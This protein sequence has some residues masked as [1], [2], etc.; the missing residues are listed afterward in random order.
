[1]DGIEPAKKDILNCNDGHIFEKYS[2]FRVKYSTSPDYSLK[3]HLIEVATSLFATQFVQEC[4]LIE[5]KKLRKDEYDMFMT[6]LH[7][8]NNKLMFT[9]IDKLTGEYYTQF[10]DAVLNIYKCQNE[11]LISQDINTFNK[12][13]PNNVFIWRKK[14]SSDLNIRI[15]GEKQNGKLDFAVQSGYLLDFKTKHHRDLIDPFELVSVHFSSVPDFISSFGVSRGDDI[16]LPAFVLQWMCNEHWKGE[17]KKYAIGTVCIAGIFIGAGIAG[18]GVVSKEV[19][20]YLV[21]EKGKEFA[22]A[23]MQEIIAGGIVKS[24]GQA[25]INYF[26]G[27]S[28]NVEEE[29]LKTFTSASF[30]EGAVKNA[31]SSLTSGFEY[32]KAAE[33]IEIV[34]KLFNDCLNGTNIGLEDIVKGEFWTKEGQIKIWSG[35]LIGIVKT[36]FYE[37][38]HKVNY[39]IRKNRPGRNFAFDVLEQAIV[40]TINLLIDKYGVDKVLML[41]DSFNN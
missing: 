35:C 23:F 8:D 26:D 19:I 9:L 17:I 20:T 14:F 22:L 37:H 33:E 31:V 6:D 12:N 40:D 3:Y 15:L 28:F 24:F 18:G 16:L 25:A 41:I 7:K 10:V 11:E 36:M 32:S 39:K 2:L 38:I 4:I 29:A 30:Y 27:G 34:V 13:F 21:K 1:M 5:I